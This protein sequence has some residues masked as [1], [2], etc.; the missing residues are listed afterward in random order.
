MSSGHWHSSRRRRSST[1]D[2]VTTR[3]ERPRDPAV[4]GRETITEVEW[5]APGETTED[6][7]TDVI[8]V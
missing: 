1:P 7:H 3:L 5:G 6:V 4:R 2:T 8:P